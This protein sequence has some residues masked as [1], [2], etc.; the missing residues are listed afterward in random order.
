MPPMS[1]QMPPLADLRPLSRVRTRGTSAAGVARRLGRVVA[2]GLV[3]ALVLLHG[4]LLW[5]RIA[6]LT[7]FEPWVALRWGIAAGAFAGFVYLQ[8]AGVSVV[9]GHRALVL[10]L[11]V[12]VC[13]ASVLPAASQQLLAEPGLM[14]AVSLSGFA[15]RAF[16]EDRRAAVPLALRGHRARRATARPRALIFLEPLSPRP[17]PAG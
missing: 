6:S 3:A 2:S 4:Q 15:L 17:P 1:I 14:L 7:L 16:L 13:H 11:L 12:L 9:R 5:Q 10:W 8:R